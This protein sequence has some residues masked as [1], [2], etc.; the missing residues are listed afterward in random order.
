MPLLEFEGCRQRIRRAKAHREAIAKLWNEAAQKEDFYT[1]S[2]SMNDDGTGCI[3]LFPS[4][5]RDFTNA[6][7]LQ[8]GEMIYQLRATLDS[9]VYASAIR[10]SGQNPPPNENKWEFPL[11]QKR[12][13]YLSFDRAPLAQ[14]RR[15]IIESVQP[16]NVPKIAPDKLVF[17]QNRALGILNEW[18]RRDRHRRLHVVGSWA[19]NANPKI[20]CP[21]GTVLSRL[22]VSGSGFLEDHDEIATFRLK[23]FRPG[24]KVQANP[25][26]EIEI[27]VNEIPPP[28]A[29]N[30]T[31]GNRLLAMLHSTALVVASIE[32][33][34]FTE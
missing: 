19:S 10:E 13:D 9:A 7:A 22:R 34:F 30:D 5:G 21:E 24:M 2:V 18:A 17:N 14:K 32:K 27:G 12:C 3:A 15:D 1:V 31:L 33:S 16:Y 8:L 11:C 23:G 20:R 25:D 28:C 26:V 29:D 4:Y 6:I